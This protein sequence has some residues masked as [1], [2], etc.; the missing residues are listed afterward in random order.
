MK[1][2]EISSLISANQHHR[3]NIKLRVESVDI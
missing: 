2:G 3:E 1:K